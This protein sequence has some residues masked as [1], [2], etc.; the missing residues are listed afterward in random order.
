M[1]MPTSTPLSH[2]P[3]CKAKL[4]RGLE[5][6]PSCQ[7]SVSKMQDYLV[8]MQR[9]KAVG[10]EP[11]RTSRLPQIN[12]EW[13]PPVKIA[14]WGLGILVVGIV[15]YLSVGF[16]WQRAAPSILHYPTDPQELI[17][18]YFRL[19]EQ[20]KEEPHHQA[21]TLQ[22][23]TV[24]HPD[25][26]DERG[27]YL[28]LYHVLNKYLTG[29]IGVGWSAAGIMVVTPVD[30][31]AD[32]SKGKTAYLV[33][34]GLETLH[35]E[36]IPQGWDPTKP[37]NPPPTPTRYGIVN[38]EEFPISQAA[39]FIKL[40]AITGVF[41]GVGGQGAGEN[42][43]T[44]LSLGGT[45][46]GR[47]TPMQTKYRVLPMVRDPE[48]ANIRRGLLHLWPVR[49]DLVVKARLLSIMEDARY[50]LEDQRLAKEVLEERVAP[51]DLMA[52]GVD[53]N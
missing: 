36:I 29:E 13:T 39:Q 18:Q 7:M 42:L 35:V 21:F 44:V 2:C 27:Q 46:G 53:I 20:D 48:S 49:R 40:A 14:A 26:S 10:M 52:V 22:S 9:A 33:K 32:P 37:D 6:C 1:P 5:A 4:Q 19:I 11:V 24:L 3:A 45:G 16:L 17:T 51:E 8:A 43:Q 15:L 12:I 31:T 41:R 25:K 23:L 47:E 28:Q 38:I 34:I 30:P 50:T